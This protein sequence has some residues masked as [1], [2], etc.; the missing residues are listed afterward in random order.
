[1]T[2]SPPT[3]KPHQRI[4]AISN[5][6]AGREFE[7]AARR[8]LS[9]LGMH[10][11]PNYSVP[12]GHDQK[13]GHR[14]DL[15]SSA[16]PVLVECKS[17]SW[18]E[19]GRSPSAKLRS[20]NEAMLHFMLAPPDYRKLLIME[21]TQH[22]GRRESLGTYYVRTQGHLI[23]SDVEVWE[24]DPETME[25]LLLPVG[26]APEP[27]AAARPSRSK[28][29]TNNMPKTEHFANAI[30]ARLRGAELRG[31][32]H[33]DINSGE[34]HR[35]LGGYPGPGAAMPSCCNALYAEQSGEDRII[36]QPPKGKGA[37]L[38]IRY[39]LPR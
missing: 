14:F 25:G 32:D 16:P 26:V 17:Y 29:G 8:F 34:L 19:T 5:A 18:T 27:K 15:G 7:E 9:G 1:M 12:V 3:H 35:S 36:S 21:K 22:I 4:G 6:H 13:K 30:R 20:L 37:S 11:Q 23:P 39:K 33:L 28:T 31:E 38:T 24:L 2:V 10:L